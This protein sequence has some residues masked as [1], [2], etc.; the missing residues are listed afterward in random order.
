MQ[1]MDHSFPTALLLGS[2][3]DVLTQGHYHHHHHE[4]LC[5]VPSFSATCLYKA[6]TQEGGHWEPGNAIFTHSHT[7]TRVDNSLLYPGSCPPLAG[8]GS[9]SGS[10]A[11]AETNAPS[12]Q[13]VSISRPYTGVKKGDFRTPVRNTHDHPGLSREQA[14]QREGK[15]NSV[16]NN[17][18]LYSTICCWDTI[19][20]RFSST[21]S[22]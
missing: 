2:Y 15:C 16:S 8:L 11:F 20:Q 21:K 7:H 13:S 17:L 1:S 18:L 19:S 4:S 10:G 14:Q 5:P 12:L 6:R 22:L 3:G 9:T